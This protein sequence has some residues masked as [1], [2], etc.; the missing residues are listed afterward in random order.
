MSIELII[1]LSSFVVCVLAALIWGAVEKRRR[2]PH[3]F[4]PEGLASR[5]LYLEKQIK[6]SRE[7]SDFLETAY[8]RG[9]KV[10]LFVEVDGQLAPSSM[11]IGEGRR[12]VI[13]YLAECSAGFRMEYEA[14]LELRREARF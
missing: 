12:E 5:I 8:K 11:I 14:R 13:K 4:G 7:F 6:L 9:Y 3:P 2:K 10:Q 1:Y